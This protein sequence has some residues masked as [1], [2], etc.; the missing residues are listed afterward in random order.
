[1]NRTETGRGDYP[2][3]RPVG[4]STGRAPKYPRYARTRARG[5]LKQGNDDMEY[6]I[7][8]DPVEERIE[9]INKALRSAKMPPHIRKLLKGTVKNVA[10]LELKL[11]E[12]KDAIPEG[13]IVKEY[14]NG[15]GQKGTQKSPALKAYNDLFREYTMGMDEI[16]NALPKDSKEPMKRRARKKE[17]KNVFEQIKEQ[18]KNSV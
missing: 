11:D 8:T 3:P 10:W 5:G 6:D 12:A 7:I 16:L 2:L 9:E 17:P 1:M 4:A 14:D 18:Q 15:G 13:E